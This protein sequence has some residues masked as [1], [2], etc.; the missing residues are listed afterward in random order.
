[1]E[2]DFGLN[3]EF[4]SKELKLLFAILK[5]QDDETVQTYSNEWF[6]DIDWEVFLEQAVHH[7]VYP[8]IYQKLK[9]VDEELIPS[10]IVQTLN[11]K[12]KKN[13]FQ[14][15]YLSAEMERIN[16]LCNENEIRMIFLKGPVL[17][18]DLY[19][20]ISLRTSCD[21]DVLIP[22]QNLEKV[23]MLLLEQGYVKDDYIQ[24]ILNDWK[25]RHHHITFFHPIKRIKV[26]IHWRLNPGPGKEPGFEELWG[27]KRKSTLTSNSV[28][29]L[30]KEDLFLFL[31]SH[32][33]RHGWSRLRW[34]VD[35]KKIVDQELNW[36]E[37]HKLMRKYQ[38]LHLGGQALIL[39]AQLLGVRL[40]ERMMELV[41]KKHSKQ[42]AQ[43]ALFYFKQMINLHTDP[44]PEEVFIYH[45][46]YLFS[47]MSNQQ[48]ILY[49]MSQLYPYPIDAKTLP[50]PKFLHFL[51]FP[52]RPFLCL[53]R[54][55][56]K[57][58]L[59]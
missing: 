52:L 22:M 25:W 58:A 11:R 55:T 56:K 8:V 3:V 15:L 57:L 37:I 10:H 19:G 12:Y 30:G 36:S 44:V 35:I 38:M 6:S 21:L 45:S 1:M 46:R 39:A 50:L 54:K 51:Y 16:K 34:L 13:T 47:L 49:I 2:K 14:M 33:A 7:R 5:L 59:L 40:D 4:M 41:A 27:R 53:W 24:T 48:K 18:Q 17:S 31:V 28:Y 29:M 43:E 42:L 20:D 26:E 32:G 9:Q 23:E